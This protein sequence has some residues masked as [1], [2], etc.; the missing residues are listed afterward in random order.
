[1]LRSVIHSPAEIKLHR[2]ACVLAAD[3][4]NMVEEH[5]Q[6][7]MSTDDINDLVHEYT[8]KHHG[9]PA[10]LNYK[11]FPKSVCTSVNEVV[12]HGIPNDRALVDGD[13]VNVD[14]VA[15]LNGHHG[16]ASRTFMVGNS[17]D[18]TSRAL[19]R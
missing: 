7:G 14:I 4:L 1:M 13:I 6:P 10:P 5:L 8:L 3:T 11:G 9:R 2:K 15:Y 18:E 19:V 12:C 17:V 16:D